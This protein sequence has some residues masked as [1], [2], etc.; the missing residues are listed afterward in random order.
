MDHPPR[1]PRLPPYPIQ[2]NKRTRRK[3]L[4]ATTGPRGGGRTIRSRGHPQPPTSR[5]Q[6]TIAIPGQVAGVPRK[7]QHVGTRRKST[8]AGTP[9]RVPPSS[10]R[11]TVKRSDDSLQTTSPILASPSTY[12]TRSY[13]SLDSPVPFWNL[14][15]PTWDLDAPV[16]PL[17]KPK[18]KPRR[19]KPKKVATTVEHRHTH[20]AFCRDPLCVFHR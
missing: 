12:Q 10:P 8:D 13:Y 1:V 6:K 3:L 7:R 9:K 19:R 16:Q 20:A 15:P 5:A 4:P 2:R 17:P 14:P 11:R 18:K